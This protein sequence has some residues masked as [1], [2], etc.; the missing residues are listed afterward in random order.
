MDRDISFAVKE[1]LTDFHDQ[2]FHGFLE[3]LV[4]NKSIY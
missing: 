4:P 3:N 2:T 1:S